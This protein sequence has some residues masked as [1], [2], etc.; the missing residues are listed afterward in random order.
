MSNIYWPIYKSLESEV[1]KLSYSINI[2][3]EQ[4]KS[5]S[6]NICDIILRAGAEIESISKELYSKNACTNNKNIKFDFDA[7]QQLHHLWKLDKKIVMIR[8]YKCFLT[9]NVINP[10]EKNEK[11]DFNGSMT[12]SWN[13]SYQH[14][15]HNREESLHFGNSR[16]MYNIM[17]ALFVLNLY[18]KD[19]IFSY[20]N[21]NNTTNFA[22]NLD[23]DVF[24]IKLH[25][26]E[27]YDEG[28]KYKKNSDFDECVY[29]IKA[30][31]ESFEKYKNETEARNTKMNKL[32]SQHPKFIQ[33]INENKSLAYKG[34]NIY[35]DALGQ[36]DYINLVKQAFK[37]DNKKMLCYEYEAIL[38][39]NNI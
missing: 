2:N 13:N 1:Q 32:F 4:Q 23:S 27:G 36:E 37:D 9:T 8:N 20:N 15:K 17:A 26:C 22:I 14:L 39:K 34:N 28:S 38:N 19:A 5:L 11:S 6:S 21:E 25:K 18:Y 29:L 3:V 30:T 16:Y 24:S 31:D 12:Y 7:L 35:W 33:Y 10:F